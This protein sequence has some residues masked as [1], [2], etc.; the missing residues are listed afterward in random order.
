MSG[1]LFGLF[2]RICTVQVLGCS[3]PSVKLRW[4]ESK[5]SSDCV[6]V[7]VKSKSVCSNSEVLN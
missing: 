3:G 2:S 5:T 1:S 4:A 6:T 7:E